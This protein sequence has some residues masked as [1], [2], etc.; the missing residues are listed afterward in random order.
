M[1]YKTYITHTHTY[2]F[3][4]KLMVTECSK[5]NTCFTFTAIAL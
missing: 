3:F 1:T 4:F 2:N 5:M